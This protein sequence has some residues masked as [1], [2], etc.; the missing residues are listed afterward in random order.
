M[1]SKQWLNLY[2]ST[3]IRGTVVERGQ[4]RQLRLEGIVTWC[5][6]HVIELLPL[7]LQIGLYFLGCAVFLS[8]ADANTTVSLIA[9]GLTSFKA[10][11]RIILVVAGAT[12]DGCSYQT[13][14]SHFLRSLKSRLS[15][16]PPIRTRRQ[17]QQMIVLEQ[18]R[19]SLEQQTTALNSR[20]ISWIL[21]TS[22]DKGVRLST[23]KY[24]A[25]V[26]KQL[27]YGDRAR[28]GSAHD[29][30]RKVF[31]PYPPPLLDHRLQTP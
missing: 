23:L 20:C 22:L 21:W 19:I 10:L 13:F 14:A 26:S 2:E 16:T 24:L 15:T 12:F 6:T 8:L 18:L 27:L 28:V 5:F 11:L 1:L 7:A 30:V 3:D 9:L 31:L 17:S 4:H 25:S 29:G